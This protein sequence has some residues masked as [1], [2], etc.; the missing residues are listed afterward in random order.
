VLRITGLPDA[1]GRD[2]ELEIMVTPDPSCEI[3]HN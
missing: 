1:A 2:M 3:P